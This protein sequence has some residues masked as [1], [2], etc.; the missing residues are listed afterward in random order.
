[1]FRSFLAASVAGLPTPWARIARRSAR[2]LQHGP[3][4]AA[5]DPVDA[6][7]DQHLGQVADPVR[8]VFQ[9][10]QHELVVGGDAVGK[11]Q[12][13]QTLQNRTAHEYGRLRPH[14]AAVEAVP[15][16]RPARPAAN[17]PGG[18]VATHRLQV[19]VD[20]LDNWVRKGG[21]DRGPCLT[22]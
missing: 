11:V 14:P 8:V 19:A 21:R 10:P 16:E 7:P 13:P 3:G 22:A 17:D 6:H 4:R 9:Q 18:V 12:Q 15:V 2:A 1:M 5:A 20:G